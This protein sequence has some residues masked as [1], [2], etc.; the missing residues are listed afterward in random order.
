MERNHMVNMSGIYRM[1]TAK[2]IVL[3]LLIDD[4]VSSLG[5]RKIC[6]DARYSKIGVSVSPHKEWDTCAVLDMF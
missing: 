1:N 5:H 4:R 3:Q 6:L 2:D